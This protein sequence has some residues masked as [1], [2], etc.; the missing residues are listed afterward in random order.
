MPKIQNLKKSHLSSNS[1]SHK[2]KVHLFSRLILT[3]QVCV[4]SVPDAQ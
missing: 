4:G 2:S 3:S 1:V